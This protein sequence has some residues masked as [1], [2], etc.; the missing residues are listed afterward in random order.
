MTTYC[1]TFTSQAGHHSNGQSG[2]L[3]V[4]TGT[5]QNAGNCVKHG[6]D[7]RD[8]KSKSADQFVRDYFLRRR[9]EKPPEQP[10]LARGY[11]QANKFSG[12]NFSLNYVKVGFD[13]AT[14]RNP[15]IATGVSSW[16]WGVNA[17]FRPQKWMYGP[18]RAFY[19]S[20]RVGAVAGLSIVNFFGVC[21]RFDEFFEVGLRNAPSDLTDSIS[22]SV[23]GTCMWSEEQGLGF[24]VR[25]Y[26]GQDYYNASFLDTIAR[27][28]FGVTI[29]RLKA[30]GSG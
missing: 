21:N 9:G 26:S 14:H 6:T 5:E 17:E 19:P 13:R 22:I 15:A 11:I 16:R 24:F 2:C 10:E 30:F 12:G 8:Q 1:P 23:Q 4:W 20:W 27:I 3:F 7:I 28:H 25:Y 29:N 18:M